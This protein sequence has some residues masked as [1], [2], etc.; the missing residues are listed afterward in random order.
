V[1]DIIEETREIKLFV[2][3]TNGIIF[4]ANKSFMKEVL[5]YSKV[6]TRISIKAGEPESLTWRTGAEGRFYELPFKAVKYFN[7]KAEPLK[8]FRVAAMTDPRIMSSSE[9]K[10]LLGGYGKLTLF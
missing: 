5:D 2:L 3:E 7:D 4:G 6:Y 9:R 1:L 8:R 10:K